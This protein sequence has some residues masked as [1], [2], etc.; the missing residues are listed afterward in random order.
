MPIFFSKFAAPFSTEI[1]L[2][3]F[4][5]G[6]QPSESAESRC[7]G[8]QWQHRVRA[9]RRRRGRCNFIERAAPMLNGEITAGHQRI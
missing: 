5:V 8:T 1:Y 9:R 6:F 4:A 3:D 2:R 7:P